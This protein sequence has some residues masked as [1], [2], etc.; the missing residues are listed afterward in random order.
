M[1]RD[2]GSQLFDWKDGLP[3][4][5]REAKGCAGVAR[6]LT[7]V[8][9]AK[10]TDHLTVFLELDPQ[11]WQAAVGVGERAYTE[12]VV[13]AIGTTIEAATSLADEGTCGIINCEAL[14]LHLMP[15]DELLARGVTW[16]PPGT[17]RVPRTNLA[18]VTRGFTPRKLA[19]QTDDDKDALRLRLTA[20]T[21]LLYDQD[22]LTEPGQ[23]PYGVQVLVGPT[24]GI[25]GLLSDEVYGQM[26][27][28]SNGWNFFLNWSW[29]E[30]QTAPANLRLCHAAATVQP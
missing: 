10:G 6:V 29:L 2:K 9:A 8:Q 28:I 20:W 26:L 15:A 5:C 30:Q 12:E 17:F 7:H 21:D 19:K 27:A 18:E 11:H 13:T 16:E 25:K 3:A 14:L 1:A 23:Y 24:G 22:W 4:I